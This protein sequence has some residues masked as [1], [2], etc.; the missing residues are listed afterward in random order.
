MLY[1]L[2]PLKEGYTEI[3]APCDF[4]IHLNKYLNEEDFDFEEW[5][6]WQELIIQAQAVLRESNNKKETREVLESLLE[7]YGA[8]SCVVLIELLSVTRTEFEEMTS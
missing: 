7:L 2:N 3:R 6:E 5:A 1:Y 4:L 8:H